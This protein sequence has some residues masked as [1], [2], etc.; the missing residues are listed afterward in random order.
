MCELRVPPTLLHG[1]LTPTLKVSP[2]NLRFPGYS[3]K[4]SIT[5]RSIS[6]PLP[7]CSLQN[8]EVLSP[9]SLIHNSLPEKPS[10]H[11]VC[12]FNLCKLNYTQVG[13][14]NRKIYI[15]INTSQ[16]PLLVFSRSS[17]RLFQ[18][19]LE[20]RTAVWALTRGNRIHRKPGPQSL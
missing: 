3:M 14:Q 6:S 19:V 8:L 5:A 7:F 16:V 17:S 4:A 18:L 1:L 15:Y 20:E 13:R 12:L 2:L 10:E 11:D 9:Y